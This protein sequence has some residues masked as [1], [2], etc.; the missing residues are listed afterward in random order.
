MLEGGDERIEGRIT[1]RARLLRPCGRNLVVR[2]HAPQVLPVIEW[3]RHF[4]LAAFHPFR[5]SAE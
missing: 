3:L 4:P 2:R 1:G 5:R